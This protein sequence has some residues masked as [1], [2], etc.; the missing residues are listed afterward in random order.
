MAPRHRRTRG[1]IEELPSGSFRA[2]VYAGVDPLTGKSR[3]LRETAKDY[4]LAEKAL[5]RLQLQVDEDRHPKSAITLRKAIEQW[6]EVAELEDTTRERYDDLIRLYVLPT[7]GDMQAGRLDAELVERFYARLQKCRE[8]HSGRPPAGHVCRPLSSSTVRKIHFIIRGALERAVRWRHLAVN[9]AALALAPTPAPAEPDPPSPEEAAALL[10]EAWRD[11]EWGLMLW[12]T[13][14]SGSRRGEVCALRWQHVDL[15]RAVLWIP[16]SIA[17]TK[18]GLKDKETKSGKARRIA[19]DPHTLTLLAEHRQRWEQRC[20]LL[21]CELAADAFMFSPAPDASTPFIP[22]SITQRYRRMAIRLKLRST[23][24]HSLRHYSATEL[25]AAGVNLR[26]VAGRLGHGSGGA[27]TLKVYAAWVDEADRRAAATMA[28]IMPRPVPAP[29]APRGPYETIA[30]DLRDDITSGRLKPGDQLPTVVEIA[31][32]Y[33][34]AAGTAHRAMAL[35][36]AEGLIDVA[37][38]RRAVVRPASEAA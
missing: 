12:L 1:H 3:Y 28:E 16:R 4:T 36:R 32:K 6:L 14:L 19:L 2:V 23:R 10:N 34:V 5:T 31:A 11:P 27:T 22:R 18:Q 29:R 30:A 20:A 17:Q 13:M 8:L 37:R 7:F 21:G 26:T 33:T 25:L 24:L 15:D 38:G 9:K 35:L